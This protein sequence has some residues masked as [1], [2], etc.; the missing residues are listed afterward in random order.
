[1]TDLYVVHSFSCD[2]S[3][4]ERKK[5]ETP[6]IEEAPPIVQAEITNVEPEIIEIKEEINKVDEPEIKPE[7]IKKVKKKC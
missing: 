3:P 2:C 4:R 7:K 5:E 1:M 6:Q